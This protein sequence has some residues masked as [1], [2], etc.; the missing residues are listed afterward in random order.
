MADKIHSGHLAK[1]YI[2]DKLVGLFDSIDYGANIML[3]PAFILGRSSGAEV[4]TTG[5]DV[6]NVSLNGFRIVG[7]GVH[8]LPK[9]PKV[10]DL[11]NQGEFKIDVI[12]RQTGDP[13]ATILRCKWQRYGTGF[14]A[15]SLTRV[16]MSCI[17]L[18]LQDESG[19]QDE[20]PGAADLP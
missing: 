16:Q 7:Q 5:F 13:V 10:Q 15:R 2:D 18:V 4:V 19:D 17:G 1:I 20:G 3:E 6:V 11:V 8:V 9:F 12:D 14:S